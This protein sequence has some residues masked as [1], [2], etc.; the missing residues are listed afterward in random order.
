M[1]CLKQDTMALN[2]TATR[3]FSAKGGRQKW[4]N[5]NLNLMEGKKEESLGH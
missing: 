1:N 5:I 2:K 4:L 3:L